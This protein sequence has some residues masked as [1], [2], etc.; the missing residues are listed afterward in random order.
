MDLFLKILT[1]LIIVCASPGYSFRHK[2]PASSFRRRDFMERCPLVKPM[3]SLQ[4]ADMMGFWYI[5][6]YYSSSEETAEYKC[7]KGNLEMSDNKDITMKF[8]YFFINDPNN[9]LMSGNITWY[10]PNFNDVSHW[11]HAEGFYEGVYNTYIIDNYRQ[12]WALIMHCAEKKRS[13]RYLSA[14]MLSRTPTLGHNVKVFLREKLPQYNIDLDYMFDVY[15]D[16]CKEGIATM[17]EY[18]RYVLKNKDN[19]TDVPAVDKA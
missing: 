9:E 15:Q 19:S 17:D 6:Q 1:L 10:I 7:M 8:T 16:D 2:T 18:Y 12:D 3:R 11:I 14:L 13:S 4:L 5:I